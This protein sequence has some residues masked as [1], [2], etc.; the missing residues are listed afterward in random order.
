MCPSGSKQSFSFL[1]F[2][3]NKRHMFAGCKKLDHKVL[4]SVLFNVHNKEKN[5]NQSC[6]SMVFDFRL[7]LLI[8]LCI[9]NKNR[10]TGSRKQ[11]PKISKVFPYLNIY[12]VAL[13]HL[14]RIQ[15]VRGHC[16][17]GCWQKV[18]G[19]LN[20]CTMQQPVFLQKLISGRF[21]G[22]IQREMFEKDPHIVN[23]KFL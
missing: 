5:I 16:H 1:S 23:W 8:S 14:C 6:F 15:I 17:L 20:L 22:S 21:L 4:Q 3:N 10:Q 19:F 11:Q 2:V 7:L 18:G 13:D 12:G 9:L